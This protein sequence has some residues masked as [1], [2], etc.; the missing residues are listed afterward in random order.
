MKTVV[1]VSGA[2]HPVSRR[3]ALTRLEAQA[4]SL[5]AKLGGTVR[6]LHAGPSDDQLREALGHGLGEADWLE[7]EDRVDPVPAL[8][9]HLKAAAPDIVI[10]GRRGEGT[11]D[12]GLVPYALAE[13]LDMPIIADVVGVS[14]GAGSGTVSIEQA[15]K[16]GAR[17][18]LVVQLPVL[19]T[20]H[21]LAPPPSPFAFAAARR[22]TIRHE[23]IEATGLPTAKPSPFVERPYRAR[24]KMMRQAGAGQAGEKAVLVGPT[25]EEA[26]ERIL[27]FLEDNGIRRYSA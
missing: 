5:A 18:R 7:I 14:P 20:I 8:I 19:V 10:A 25:P 9:D 6:G 12:T 27:A 22:G 4:A 26:A 13:A 1:L 24:P 3:P 15:L 23:R 11:G 21:P 17:R 16:K 2:R